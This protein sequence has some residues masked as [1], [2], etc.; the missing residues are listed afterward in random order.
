MTKNVYTKQQFEEILALAGVKEVIYVQV[1]GRKKIFKGAIFEGENIFIQK[2]GAAFKET[3]GYENNEIVK[4][5]ALQ[6]KDVKIQVPYTL[7]RLIV[8][9]SVFDSKLV[10]HIVGMVALHRLELVNLHTA[11][12][13]R[14]RLH[15]EQAN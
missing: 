12:V 11:I 14:I 1:I 3:I 6:D 7:D 10:D 15:H 8:S 13:D 2:N 9:T 4:H 5:A